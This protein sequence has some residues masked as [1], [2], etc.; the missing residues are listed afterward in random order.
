[1]NK[2]YYKEY[3]NHAMR[4]YARNLALALGKPGLTKTDIDNWN[5]CNDAIRMFS[6][7]EQTIL[8]IV[9]KSKCTMTD[10]V[11]ATASQL[12][13]DKNDIWQ[14]LNR[15]SKEFAKKRGLI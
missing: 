8:I 11:Q 6:Q 7:Q 13:M 4:F 5:A 15:F 3:A 2:P 12:H 10:A 1:M 9:Y 14:L